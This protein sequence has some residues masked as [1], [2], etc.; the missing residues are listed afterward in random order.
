MCFGCRLERSALAAFMWQASATRSINLSM[1]CDHM[2]QR[3]SIF[4]KHMEKKERSICTKIIAER[5]HT[6]H[7]RQTQKNRPVVAFSL[8][9]RTKNRRLPLGNP[10]CP[11][12]KR[13][14]SV[15]GYSWR[16]CWRTPFGGMCT[17]A[18]FDPNDTSQFLPR[19]IRVHGVRTGMV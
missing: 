13:E 15:S 16:C 12:E 11:P 2:T 7:A 10:H 5:S 1:S 9:S 8:Y 17:R 19:H 18:G 14:V 3:T 4:S 6:H